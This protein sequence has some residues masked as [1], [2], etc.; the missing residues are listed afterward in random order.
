MA[1]NSENTSFSPQ[2]PAPKN[3]QLKIVIGVLIAFLLGTWGYLIWDKNKTSDSIKQ[4]QAQYSNVD[5]ARNEIQ[6]EYDVAL[7]RLDSATES[8]TQL[9]GALAERQVEIDGL[10]SQISGLTKKKNATAADLKKAKDLIAKLNGRIDDMFTEI[11]RLKGENE[12][13]TTT[14]TQLSTE[15]Q[16]LTTEKSQLQE[17][18][19]TTEAAKKNVEDIASTLHASNMNITTL[20]I[21]G[22]GKEK[23]TT[24]AKRVDVLRIGFQ[25][26]E[27]R[28]APS[29]TK[30]LY[31]LVTGP[32]GKAVTMASGSGTF[33]TREEGT[34]TYTNKILVPYEQGRKVPVSFDW[35]QEGKYQLGTYKIEVYH[36]GFKIGEGSKSLKKGGLF[37]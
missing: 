36:N 9:Q 15:K 6:N 13:L 31:V 29:G 27:N 34:K 35:K 7:A 32:D 2:Q 20:D 17:N 5:S 10:K 30:E 24:T 23:E 33:E 12:Q 21:K 3:D 14:N 18:L 8:N 25:I 11:Q 19:N 1:Y 37:D 22:S 26:D 4:L 16:Q 28:V